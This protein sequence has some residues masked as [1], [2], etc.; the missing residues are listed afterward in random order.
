MGAFNLSGGGSGGL[1]SSSSDSTLN[2]LENM[3]GALKMSSMKDVLCSEDHSRNSIFEKWSVLSINSGDRYFLED[4]VGRGS[5]K[6]RNIE[7]D[8]KKS[9]N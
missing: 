5:R 3:A 4:A 8:R 2:N 6:I 7:N 1:E 9:R